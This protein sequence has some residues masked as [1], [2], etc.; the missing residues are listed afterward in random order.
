MWYTPPIADEDAEGLLRD[1]YDKDIQ[2][3]GYI[4][5]VSRVWSYRPE[6]A[7]PWQQLLK[8]IRSH[9]RLRAYELATLA[10]SRA[11]PTSDRH[12]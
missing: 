7:V 8:T 3:N 12:P 1:L 9:M 6:L 4:R 5:N 10:A 2:E 11:C